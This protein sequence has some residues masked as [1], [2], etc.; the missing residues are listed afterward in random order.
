MKRS[1]G[2][3]LFTLFVLIV[4][5]TSALA[6]SDPLISQVDPTD[7]QRITA[8][9]ANELVELER[10]GRGRI[11][12]NMAYSPDGNTLAVSSALGVWLYDARTLDPD[13]A[14]LLAGLYEES[15]SSIAFS[16]DGKLLALGGIDGTVRLWDAAT[17]M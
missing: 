9:N 2:W 1:I 14:V 8:E 6:T 10:L 16:P 12:G 3:F 15:A 17:G 4:L 13:T 7:L 5:A 11:T